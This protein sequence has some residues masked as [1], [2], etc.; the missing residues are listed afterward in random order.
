MDTEDQNTNDQNNTNQTKDTDDQNQNQNNND[1]G[2]EERERLLNENSKLRKSL[3]ETNDKFKTLETEID[4]MKK[5][6]HKSKGDW[7][8][9]AQMMEE[10]LAEVTKKHK[11][12][13]N[14]FHNTLVSGKVREEALKKGL[15]PDLVDLLDNMEMESVVA[16]IE[17]GKYNVRGYDTFIDNL[18][19][20]RPS[21]FTTP[22]PPKINS[23]SNPG[24]EGGNNTTSE[25]D[26]KEKYLAALANRAKDPKA[27]AAAA[28]EYHKAIKDSR[29]QK[30]TA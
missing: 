7:Q 24:F 11:D 26:A 27:F 6:G 12:A 23:G 22:N 4:E 30:A 13:V 5:S 20:D 16:E 18:K 2:N 25:K 29:K 10:K 1:S 3:K 21:L 19:R 8:K 28:V 15:K 9:Y 14:A 17:N